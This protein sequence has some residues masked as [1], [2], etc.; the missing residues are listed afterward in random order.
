MYKEVIAEIVIR[1]RNILES[2]YL[3]FSLK[4]LYSKSKST[5]I[6]LTNAKYSC[7]KELGAERDFLGLLYK[8]LF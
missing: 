7:Y 5:N 6:I 4:K 2:L 8:T 1:N 3:P